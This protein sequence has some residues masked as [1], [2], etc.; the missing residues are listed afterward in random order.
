MTNIVWSTHPSNYLWK[1][2]TQKQIFVVYNSV[3]F[4]FAISFWVSA[5]TQACAILSR[6]NLTV[7]SNVIGTR[8]FGYVCTVTFILEIWPLVKVMTHLGDGQMPYAILSRSKMTVGVMAHKWILGKCA[9][10]NWHKTYNL[11]SGH[12]TPLA[13]GLLTI[14]VWN[15]LQMQHVSKTLWRIHGFWICV[16]WGLEFWP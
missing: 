12:G 5:M 7:K 1:V 8:I 3:T 11:G 14:L 2:V 6:P 15:T 16:Q 9:L 10:W 4:A 13:L